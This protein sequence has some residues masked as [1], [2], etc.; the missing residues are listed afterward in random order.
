MILRDW[1]PIFHGAEIETTLRVAREVT[2]DIMKAVHRNAE[3]ETSANPISAAEAFAQGELAELDAGIA[4]CLAFLSKVLEDRTVMSGAQTALGTAESRMAR[5]FQKP[6]LFSGF[7]GVAWA[8]NYVASETTSG[9]FDEGS[10]EE[11][12]ETI[13]QYVLRRDSPV[14]YDLIDGLVGLGCYALSRLQHTSASRCF[15]AILG[16]LHS[17]A[18]WTRYG[19][20]WPT[21]PATLNEEAR[22]EFANGA[23]HLGM[24]HGLAGVISFLSFADSKGVLDNDGRQLLHGAG[25]FLMAHRQVGRSGT[26]A[27]SVHVGQPAGPVNWSWC[28]GDPGIAISLFSAGQALGES[29]WEDVAVGVMRDLAAHE[30]WRE[31]SFDVSLCHGYAGIGHMFNRFYHLSGDDSFAE[32]ARRALRLTLNSRTKDMGVGGFRFI[33]DRQDDQVTWAAAPGYLT[34]SAGVGAALASAC[35]SS[36]PTWDHPMMLGI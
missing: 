14:P 27:R 30:P 17:T 33:R 36:T 26:F 24:A 6:G 3:M 19:A 25:S 11:I 9:Q 28:W 34:G 22:R 7:S 10:Y 21:D 1:T 5:V 23:F 2:T 8:A 29:G 4:P 16:R 35:T 32:A 18:Q 20:A 12:D 15:Q 13:L 31:G